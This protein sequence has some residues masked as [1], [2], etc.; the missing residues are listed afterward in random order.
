MVRRI[1]KWVKGNFIKMKSEGQKGELSYT[2]CHT[3]D[4]NWKRYTFYIFPEGSDTTLLQ[5]EKRFSLACQQ[6][7]QSETK[8]SQLSQWKAVILPISLSSNGLF[9]TAHPNFPFFSIEDFLFS[10]LYE[11]STVCHSCMS[12]LHFFAA[13]KENP[14]CWE[15]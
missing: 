8:L 5:E 9:I 1:L 12:Q 11:T 10:L 4:P 13:P 3:T 6:C 2:Y 15:K 14:F 7:S